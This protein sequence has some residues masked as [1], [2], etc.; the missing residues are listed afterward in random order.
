MKIDYARASTN[1]QNLDLQ[2]DALTWAGSEKIIVA[3]AFTWTTKC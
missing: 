2:K 3:H 1:E